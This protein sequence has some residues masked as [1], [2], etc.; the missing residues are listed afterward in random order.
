[1]PQ[2]DTKQIVKEIQSVI[3]SLTKYSKKPNRAFLNGYDTLPFFT[4]QQ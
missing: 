4:L 2:A 1:M 3:D